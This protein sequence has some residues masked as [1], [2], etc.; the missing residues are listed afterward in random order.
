[1]GTLR[2]EPKKRDLQFVAIQT[3]E[4]RRPGK[5]ATQPKVSYGLRVTCGPFS[6]EIDEE[7]DPCMLREVL[8]VVGGC[9]C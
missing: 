2:F 3:K 1:M 6:I 8:R 7:F 5:H 4:Q 9:Q